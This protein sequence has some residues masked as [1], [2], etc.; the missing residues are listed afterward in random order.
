MTLRF[1]GEETPIIVIWLKDFKLGANVRNVYMDYMED[2]GYKRAIVVVDGGIIYHA[3][4]AIKTLRSQKIYID[5][6]TLAETQFNIMKHR[7]VPLHE[8]C[9]P[10]VKK[11]VMKK[12]AVNKDQLPHV[13]LF[14]PVVRHLGA[15]KG[16]LIRITRDSETQKGSKAISYRMVQ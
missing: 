10:K 9:S 15:V 2:D 11:D 14:D 16:D 5:V 6:Y 12:Y 13:K 1:P 8:I 4:N 7:W 3:T